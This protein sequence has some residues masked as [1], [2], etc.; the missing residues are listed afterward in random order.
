[1]HA[2]ALAVYRDRGWSG[3]SFDA[4]AREAGVGKNAIYLRWRTREDLLVAALERFIVAVPDL[5]RGSVHDDLLHLVASMAET[6][7]G[8]AGLTPLRILLEAH[9]A[10]SLFDRF[11]EVAGSRVAAV[12]DAIRRGV[13]RGELPA[14]TDVSVL[15]DAI[16]GAVINQVLI[17]PFD[18]AGS[19]LADP[20][21]FARRVLD[22]VLPPAAGP[23]RLE[24]PL[25]RATRTRRRSTGR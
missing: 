5:D 23:P 6:F 12:R 9:S 24:K 25:G 17:A 11:T 7:T 1:M 2:A 22:Q 15:G 8:P 3:F 20:M 13:D 18:P 14:D 19:A 10:P 21:A 16:G 4:V